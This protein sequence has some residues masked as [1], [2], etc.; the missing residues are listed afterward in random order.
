M[1]DILRELPALVKEI[2]SGTL[3]I[4]AKAIPLSQVEQVW[5]GPTHA[6]ER[7]VLTP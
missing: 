2:A 6:S 5:A 3:R 7:I 1:R 4:G